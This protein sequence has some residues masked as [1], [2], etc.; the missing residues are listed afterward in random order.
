[1][2]A[3]NG[4]FLKQIDMTFDIASLSERLRKISMRIIKRVDSI[5]EMT[6]DILKLMESIKLRLEL[7][8]DV[9]EPR[10]A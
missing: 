8:L 1:M 5:A 6:A 4:R 2:E 10:T 7:L 9:Q 3:D